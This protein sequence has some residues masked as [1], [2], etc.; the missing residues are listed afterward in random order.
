MNQNYEGFV[1]IIFS[2]MEELLKKARP[3]RKNFW[4]I[5]SRLPYS[6]FIVFFWR[7][8]SK[9]CIYTIDIHQLTTYNQASQGGRGVS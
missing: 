9:N 2:P 1:K 7:V 4:R 3:L 6:D 8:Y 5:Y